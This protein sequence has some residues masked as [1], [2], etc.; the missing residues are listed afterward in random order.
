MSN[1]DEFFT[2]EEV[3]R[4]IDQ[5]SQL[6]E[7]ERADAEAMAYLRSFYAINAQQEQVDA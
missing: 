1:Q 6:K 2:P 7:G 4:Q 3:D 5:V